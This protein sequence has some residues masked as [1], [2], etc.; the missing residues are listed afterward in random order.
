MLISGMQKR[1]RIPEW[2]KK[3][4]L[5]EIQNRKSEKEEEVSD[6]GL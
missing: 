4:E 1:K 3:D 6:L 2:G 5:A